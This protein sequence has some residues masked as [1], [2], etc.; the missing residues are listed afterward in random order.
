MSRRVQHLLAALKQVKCLGSI[1]KKKF[2]KTCNK[3]FI[4]GICECIKNVINGRVPLKS[5]QLK[6]LRR[7]KQTLRKLA[8]KKTSLLHRKKLL[9]KGGFFQVL[10]GP[11]ISGLGSLLANVLKPSNA[12]H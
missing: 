8:L 12:A 5:G 1:D 9:Q 11:L 4:H 3:D 2:L 6:C 10:L 7:H